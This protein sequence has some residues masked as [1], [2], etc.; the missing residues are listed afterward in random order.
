M[1]VRLAIANIETI[2]GAVAPHRVL[3]KARK[4]FWKVRIERL[5]VDAVGNQPQD[6]GTAA[7][8]VTAWSIGV[9]GVTARWAAS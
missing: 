1:H 4:D 7:S 8:P 6:V 5:G 2:L 3:H 9:L